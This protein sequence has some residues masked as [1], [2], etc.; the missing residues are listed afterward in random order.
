MIVGQGLL[1]RSFSPHFQDNED[2]VIFASGV[3]NSLETSHEAF[4]R[5][6]QMLADMLACNPR[7]A[8]YFGSCGVA[9]SAE[10]A[11]PYMR[12]KHDM[13]SLVL[14]HPGG[15]V[16]RL[17]QVVGITSN[18]N[19][20]TN[21]LRDR[22][23]QDE[24]FAVWAKAE[25]NLVDVDD[26][27]AISN[28]LIGSPPAQ[29]SMI[30]IASQQSLPMPEIIDIFERV[31]KRKANCVMEDRGTPL[32]IDSARALEVARHLGIDL[33]RGYAERVL[34]KYYAPH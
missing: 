27:V 32:S 18:P 26:I 17:P 22:I 33:G 15:L 12:H 10:A 24:P 9:G 20:L 25:R 21:F 2:V 34:R 6:R 31:L 19:T 5:E 7:T 16:L 1:A 23:L 28:I 4:S 29:P 11:T 8:V 13:E 3:S 14:A 30:S